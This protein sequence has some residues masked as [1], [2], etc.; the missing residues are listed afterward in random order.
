MSAQLHR[1]TEVSPEML[2]G[3]NKLVSELRET[4]PE[5]AAMVERS[6]FTTPKGEVPAGCEVISLEEAIK[7]LE[8]GR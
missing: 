6:L 1:V 4:N 8:A 5:Q 3:L 2:S 7:E